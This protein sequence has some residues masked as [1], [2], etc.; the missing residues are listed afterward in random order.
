[1]FLQ[2]SEVMAKSVELVDTLERLGLDGHF[3]REI[4]AAIGR[5]HGAG[6]ECSGIFDNLHI[7]A[8]RFRLLRQHGIWVSTG[9]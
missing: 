6:L 9:T 7:A 5:I 3:G 1:M 8:T 2:D 4:A